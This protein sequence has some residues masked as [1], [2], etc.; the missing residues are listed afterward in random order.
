MFN[1]RLLSWNHV[2]LVPY[3]QT[4]TGTS[5]ESRTW[6]FVKSGT[7]IVEPWTSRNSISKSHRCAVCG[8][9]LTC[10]GK[11]FWITWKTQWANIGRNVE[12]PSNQV[13][14]KFDSIT[15]LTAWLKT[16]PPPCCDCHPVPCTDYVRYS[17]F[18][19][20]RM[21]AVIHPPWF[22]SWKSQNRGQV[23]QRT[24]ELKS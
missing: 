8:M 7:T 22:D 5:P 4:K 21:Q 15:G 9:S 23:H 14:I 20:Q 3:S 17:S 6:Q 13:W 1:T 24:H 18:V 12:I 16:K 2:S 19:E 10:Q 11:G